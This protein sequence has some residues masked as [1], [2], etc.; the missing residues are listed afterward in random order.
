MLTDMDK[1]APLRDVILMHAKQYSNDGAD[2]SATTLQNPPRVVHLNKRHGHKMDIFVKQHL[3]SF[4]GTALH[5]YAEFLL[6]KIPN[7]PYICEERLH[8]KVANRDISGAYDLVHKKDMT[9]GDWKTTSVWK[10]MFGDY[11]D[12]T[13]QQNIYRLLYYKEHG[14]SL[15]ILKI[16]A[17]FKDW[18]KNEKFRSGPNYPAEPAM[19]Y[20][21]PV[22]SLKK[23]KD[24]MEIQVENLKAYEDTPDD[25]LPECTFDEMWCRPDQVAV[26]ST[27]IK[28]AVRVLSSMQAAKNFTKNYL[29]SPTCKDTMGTLS[30][31]VRPAKR[32]RCEE[33]CSINKYCNQYQQHLKEKAD[34]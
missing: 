12:W 11:K 7:T 31:E 32:T 4:I 8:M 25:D 9:M 2:Y 10:A 17:V 1:I 18:S 14:E 15:R 27:R 30:Y 6:N 29:G 3:A 16:I 5:N 28:K 22:W 13:A 23:T 21:M 33:W 26:K 19:E 24:Y 20:R 34:K